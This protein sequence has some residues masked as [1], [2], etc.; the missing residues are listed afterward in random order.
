[1]GPA[2]GTALEPEIVEA[3]LPV[4]QV[5]VM[6]VERS[7]LDRPDEGG[8][9]GDFGLTQ[10]RIAAAGAVVGGFRLGRIV[11]RAGVVL[12]ITV[13]CAFQKI[14]R[15]AEIGVAAPAADADAVAAEDQFDA[16]LPGITVQ[17]AHIAG[18]AGIN[19][20]V[21][22][23]TVGEDAVAATLKCK[24]DF[25]PPAAEAGAAAVAPF[26]SVA[27]AFAAKQRTGADAQFDVGIIE[28]FRT[29][30][31][32]RRDFQL[33][34]CLQRIEYADCGIG[35]DGDSCCIHRELIGLF[36]NPRRDHR[37]RPAIQRQKR[38]LMVAE[39]AAELR[40]DHCRFGYDGG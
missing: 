12:M 38:A 21:P 6:E 17:L 31:N 4:G 37:A 28:N 11:L 5:F 23:E 20:G 39:E 32:P 8:D 16:A 3:F 35:G 30:K 24:I 9:F 40:P 10:L 7:R 18:E 33:A 13:A 19:P 14:V 27:S 25:P 1:M 29:A 2:G 26:Q 36:R 15:F 34:Q 22:I